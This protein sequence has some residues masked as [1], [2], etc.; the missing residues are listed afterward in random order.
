MHFLKYS[1]LLIDRITAENDR[2]D[3]FGF[4]SPASCDKRI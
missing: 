2:F 1:N 3:L 4:F